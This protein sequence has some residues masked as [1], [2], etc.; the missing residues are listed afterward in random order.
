MKRLFT[1][2]FICLVGCHAAR[3]PYKVC[4]DSVPDLNFGGCGFFAYHLY[5]TNPI[6]YEI[7]ALGGQKHVLLFDRYQSEWID[8]KGYHDN[9]FKTGVI[10]GAFTNAT[11]PDSLLR[12]WLND[13]TMWNPRFKRKDTTRLYHLIDSVYI[14]Q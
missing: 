6:R 14:S 5:H 1:F 8:S 11:I 10:Y 7:V 12:K 13:T 2:V 9:L 4:N 3:N